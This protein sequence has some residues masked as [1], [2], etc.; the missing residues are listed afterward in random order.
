MPEEVLKQK[1]LSCLKN[2]KNV[3]KLKNVAES[4]SLRMVNPHF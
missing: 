3:K 4:R 1:K 2:V